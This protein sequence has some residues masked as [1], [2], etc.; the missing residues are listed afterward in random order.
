LVHCKQNR[1][2]GVTIGEKTAQYYV[3]NCNVKNYGG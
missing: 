3:E 2:G 1:G